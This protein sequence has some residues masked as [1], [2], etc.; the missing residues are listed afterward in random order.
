MIA[1]VSL[2]LP[3][4][5][6]STP[7][8]HTHQTRVSWVQVSA[9]RKPG[10]VVHVRNHSSQKVETGRSEIQGYTQLQG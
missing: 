6:T 7:M 5:P 2:G 4:I 3:Y 9:Q 10:M 8:Y 1:D